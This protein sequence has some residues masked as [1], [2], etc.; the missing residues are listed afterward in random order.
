MSPMGLRGPDGDFERRGDLL[1]RAAFGNQLQHFTLAWS[2]RLGCPARY[3]VAVAV[4]LQEFS[5][6]RER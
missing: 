3:R 4:R 6:D 2:E 5:C 1:G